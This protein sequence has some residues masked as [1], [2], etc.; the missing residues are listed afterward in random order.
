MPP[1]LNQIELLALIALLR[2]GEQAY[3][4]T[5]HEEIERTA[6]RRVSMAGVYAALDRLEQ[7]GLARIWHSEPRAER[8]GRSRRHYALSAAGRE[9]VRR[10]REQALRMWRG[11][12]P[13]LDGRK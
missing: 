7:R 11:L 12:A 1:T 4:V 10:E 6:G 8:G 5:V 13:D 9:L 3:G 2:L